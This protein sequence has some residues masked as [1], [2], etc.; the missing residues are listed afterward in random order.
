MRERS[1][2]LTLICFLLFLT[3]NAQKSLIRGSVSD[4]VNKKQLASASIFLLRKAD[5]VLVT[6]SRAAQDGGFS[7]E[8]QPGK[9]LFNATYPGF[10]DFS[11]SIT[12]TD[13]PLD[14]GT[15][16][17]IP[18]SK[19]LEEIIIRK[20]VPAIRM[21][22]DTIVYKADSFKVQPGATVEDLLKK[23]PGI[24]VDRS[25]KITAQ[26]EPVKK[27]LVDGEEF[28]SDDPTI[29]TRNLQS[30]MVEELEVFDKKS[31]QAEF[32]GIDD[33]KKTKT[34]NLKLKEDKKNGYFGKLEGGSNMNDYW[35]NSAMLN[36]FKGK[37]KI[38]GHGLMASDGRTGLNFREMM[39]YGGMGN[40]E[41]EMN[42]EGG[43][44]IS[45][46]GPDDDF[47]WGRF[48]GEGLPRSWSGGLQFSNKWDNDKKNI[49]VN[50]RYKKLNNDA[51][52]SN[53]SQYIL[54]DASYFAN[55]RSRTHATKQSNSGMGTY[56]VK[57]DS[58][59]SLK[60]MVNAVYG[61]G[62]GYQQ[63][64]SESITP[65]GD[66]INKGSRMNSSIN[67]TRSFSSSLIYRKKFKKPGNTFSASIQQGYNRT[68]SD[69]FLR[70]LNSYYDSK[71]LLVKAD[72]IDQEKINN[73][74]RKNYSGRLSYTK[75]LNKKTILEFNYE[76]AHADI[77]SLR[78]TLEKP[79]PLSDKYEVEVPALSNEFDFKTWENKGGMNFRYSK[80]KKFSYSFGGSMS[81]TSLTQNDLKRDTVIKYNFLN[82][83]PAAN[84]RVTMKKNM[85]LDMYYNGRT[86]Q[87]SINQLQPVANNTD[88]FNVYIGN[89]NLNLA[90]NHELGIW[91]NKYDMLSE[92][93]FF[94]NIS[95]DFAQNAF[96]ERNFIDT[97]GR[98]IYQTVNVNGNYNTRMYFN[99][100]KKLKSGL[101][102]GGGP[103]VNYGQYVN[104]VNTERNTTRNANLGAELDFDYTKEK[105]YSLSFNINPQYNLSKS[106]I[107]SI[108]TNY[109][110]QNYTLNLVVFFGKK[111][112][113]TNDINASLRQ[114][115]PVFTSNN[116]AVLWNVWL[117]RK[118]G[119]KD[120]VKL[121]LYAFDILDQNIGFRRNISSNLISEKTYNT[122]NRYLMLSFI[123]NFSKNGSPSN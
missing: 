32:T 18:R 79:N 83:F 35:S 52:V 48:E 80:P 93:G 58:S 89:P 110:L 42:D 106:S 43:T 74:D 78:R 33:G 72:V 65:G 91:L 4:T 50:Y 108:K 30:G 88:P 55:E 46:S 22:G 29:T 77:Y 103:S 26:G 10:A 36:Y 82:F 63:I 98:R 24:S 109:W 71:G 16:Y 104:Y 39:N 107:S 56:D 94:M 112:E 81:Y 27:I 116:N 120:A 53:R 113:L 101:T 67:D 105:K 115:T 14:L 19:L 57:L 3:S 70:A 119:K 97:L 38:S 92:S 41:T 117:D 87:P 76:L 62:S 118:F 90:L 37:R 73:N 44:M 99:Y 75:S 21:K 34:I 111:W 123:W 11:D 66:T 60:V 45:I 2:A 85:N 121:R 15:I 6:S 1:L 64:S 17:L 69:G 86:Q 40:V 5:S 47:D 9:Y 122:F 8:A 51:V 13:Q 49:N 31:D 96:S 68:E 7:L 100:N 23:L 20:K 84:M 25:G 54:P 114:K 61:M 12:V 59:S 28:F 102:I 95:V